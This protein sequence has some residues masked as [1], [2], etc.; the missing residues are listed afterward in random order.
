ML[1]IAWDI[2]DV[3]NDLMRT[4]LEERWK[5]HHPDCELTYE[6]VGS[7]PPHQLIGATLEEYLQS[8]DAFRLSGAYDRMAPNPDIVAWFQTHGIKYRHIALT[9]VPRKAAAVSAAWVMRHFGDW[10]RTFHFVPSP[11]PDD[12]ATRYERSKG[13]YLEWLGRVDCFIDDHPDHVRGASAA[14]VTTFLLSRPW[15]SGGMGLEKILSSLEERREEEESRQ[16]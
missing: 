8:L 11:R 14:G 1:T 16:R 9:A 4:W 5:A 7:N 12:I 10:I 3:L 13:D 2:D 15:N 6:A